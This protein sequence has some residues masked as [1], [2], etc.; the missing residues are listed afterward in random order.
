MS[1]SILELKDLS[2]SYDGSEISLKNISLIVNKAEKV[3]VLGP[4]GSGKSTLLRLIA[5]LEKPYSGTITIQ[6]KIVSDQDHMVAPEKRNV[7]LVVQNKALFPHLTVEKNIGFG[8]RKNQEK[9]KIISGLLSLFKIEHLSNKYPHEIS[10]GEQQR[11]AIARSMA[12][13]PELLMLDEPFSALDRELK[14]ELYAELNHIFNERQQT[15]MLV[16]HDLDEAKVLSDKQINL[17]N[18]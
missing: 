1:D 13:S 18:T 7:G 3:S 12:P 8:I 6:G 9:T 15:I 2:H 4:S 17:E 10:G 14:E 16:T 5:G 11:T